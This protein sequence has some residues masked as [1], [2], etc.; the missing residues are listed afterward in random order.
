LL[1]NYISGIIEP[2]QSR[3]A[4]IRFN[5]LPKEVAISRLR[6]IAESEGV[7]ISDDALEA[8]YDYTQGDM[9][10][11]INTLQIAAVTRREVTE[12]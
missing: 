3:V 2:I 5:P 11:A 8:I 7:K 6:Y 1:A 12:E 4:I 10:K 9:R